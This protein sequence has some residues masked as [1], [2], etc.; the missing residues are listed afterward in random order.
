MLMGGYWLSI[1]IGPV[2]GFIAAARR[3]RDLWYGSWL[4]S[5][6][7]KAVARSLHEQGVSLIRPG[8]EDEDLK[9]D[10]DLNVANK[11]LAYVPD[12]LRPADVFASAEQAG[13]DRLREEANQVL[14]KTRAFVNADLWEKQIDEFLEIYG[15][16]VPGK[17]DDMESRR[18]VERLLDGRKALRDFSPGY[19]K[20][21]VPKSSLDARHESVLNPRSLSDKDLRRLD[22]MTG[23]QLDAIGF[24]KRLGQGRKQYPSIGRIAA[25]PWLRAIAEKQ[26]ERLEALRRL[27]EQVPELPYLPWSQFKLFPYEATICYPS[28]LE[29]ALSGSEHESLREQIKKLVSKAPAASPY[30]AVLNADGD[31]MGAAIDGLKDEDELRKLSEKLSEF[32][33][34]AQNIIAKHY[35]AL[36]YSGGDD[37]LAFVPLDR[38]LEAA[39]D[40][41]TRFSELLEQV[42]KGGQA[43]TL[44]IGIA[45]NHYREP[46]V[47]VLTRAR[48]ALDYAKK[49]DRNGLA[50]CLYKRSGGDLLVRF[51]WDEDP[52]KRLKTWLRLLGS[53][54]VPMQAA[55]ELNMLIGRYLPQDRGAPEDDG[56][57]ANREDDRASEDVNGWIRE[58][59]RADA[60]RLLKRKEIK[61]KGSL[62]TALELLFEGLE[63]PEDGSDKRKRDR[64]W[65]EGFQRRVRMMLLAVQLL[66]VSR[67][68]DSM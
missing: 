30:M 5:E 11:I 27:A 35:G 65:T 39:R 52:D 44:S 7:S 34:E 38:V 3:T 28:R 68:S 18:D 16:W 24:V 37:V 58:A 20:E 63:E 32:A 31:R 26:P 62:Q 6:V 64:E 48:Q 42:V 41:H 14:E 2:Q 19:G 23:E 13:R 1:S 29:E 40:L 25:D 56:Q 50:F 51:R 22:L 36:V 54:S 10:S 43:P 21:R 55:Y 47:D 61:D 67:A 17:K 49:P 8:I 59:L 15:A 66:Q 4:L 12:H 57:R 53:D 9:P 60:E 46:L 45:V 33:R